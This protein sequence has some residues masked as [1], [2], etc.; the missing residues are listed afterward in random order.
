[1]LE[2]PSL[3][4][5]TPSNKQVL[6]V[7]IAR[8]NRGR[9]D[10]LRTHPNGTVILVNDRMQAE[11]IRLNSERQKVRSA[12]FGRKCL[13]YIFYDKPVKTGSTAITDAIRDYI[14]DTK[15]INQP[16]SYNSCGARAE[17]V[18]NQTLQPMHLIGH[19]NLRT[20]LTE[21]LIERG[22]YAVTSVR[23]PIERWKSAFLFNRQMKGRQYGISWSEGF[24]TF[25]DHFP[26]CVL[27]NY[28]DGMS[29]RCTS[30]E[31]PWEERLK[32]IVGRFDEVVDVFQTG[33]DGVLGSRIRKFIKMRNISK[34]EEHGEEFGAY[35]VS[36][37]VPENALYH[38]LQKI[39]LRQPNSDRFPC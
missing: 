33:R 19:V 30:G 11:E 39:R 23:K 22:Y 18:C 35:D 36:K 31:L 14:M 34:R 1:M 3:T 17:S 32:R 24:A 20:G 2:T 13:P 6:P 27:Y 25:V 12:H 15:S 7:E 8:P 9:K 28:Y 4:L 5:P 16:C 21:C 29:V 38:E 26:D 37:L 10:I